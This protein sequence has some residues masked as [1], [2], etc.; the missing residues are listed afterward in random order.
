MLQA[1]QKQVIIELK[2][3]DVQTINETADDCYAI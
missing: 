3:N 2:I 1:F